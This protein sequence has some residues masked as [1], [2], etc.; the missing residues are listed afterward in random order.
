MCIAPNVKKISFLFLACLLLGS[1]SV[2]KTKTPSY[3]SGVFFPLTKD[4]EIV[5]QGRVVDLIEREG[6]R[7]YLSTRNGMV[8]CFDGKKREVLWKSEVSDE[9]VSPPFLGRETIYV[10]DRSNILYSLD[11]KGSLLWETQVEE[12]I[13]SGVA[14]FASAV[15]LGTDKGTLF[16]LDRTSGKEI[17]RF[18]AGSSIHSTPVWAA[19]R[20]VFGCDDHNLYVLSER[21][22]LINKVGVE[23]KI[24][25]TPFIERNL[26]YF[27]ADDHHF[28]CVNLKR[29][30]KRWR[31]KTG[32]KVFTPPVAA[33]KRILFLCWNNVVYCLHKKRGHILWWQMIPSRSPFRLE[34]S[35]D[36][37]VVSSLSSVVVSFELETGKKAGQFDAKQEQEL[38]SNPV[39]Y[40]PYLLISLYD[41]RNDR[42]RLVFL[43]KVLRVSLRPSKESPQKVGEEIKFTA[44]ARGFFNPRYEFFLKEGE[45]E[46]IIQE[47]SENNSCVWIPEREGNYVVGVRVKDEKESSSAEIPFSIESHEKI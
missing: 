28:Y 2:L 16:A 25:S 17:W 37:V 33:G 38:R 19:G 35:G 6:D 45:K 43:K 20:I 26:A 8:Y 7:V 5:Y 3:P 10:Y 34:L 13:T 23:G 47:S 41:H 42:G 24:Q 4:G 11:K 18:Q 39:W 40:S 32:G 9:L 21:G 44:S 1:C 27:G 31:V 14:E 46:I 15:C 29:R 22:N 36:R 30:K 12:R